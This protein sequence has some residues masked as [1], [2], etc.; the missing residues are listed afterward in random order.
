MQGH[1]GKYSVYVH[2]SEKASLG[3]IW[4]SKVFK[5]REIRSE[6]V[7]MQGFF[8]FSLLNFPLVFRMPPRQVEV[9]SNCALTTKPN[10]NVNFVSSPAPA[11][12]HIKSLFLRF[13][14]RLN[15]FYLSLSLSLSLSFI[16]LSCRHGVQQWHFPTK[17]LKGLGLQWL[18]RN[19]DS[20]NL[21]RIERTYLQVCVVLFRFLDTVS[22]CI[23]ECPD[24]EG[25]SPRPR[26]EN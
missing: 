15:S 26:A 9:T 22:M 20:T 24:G 12:M 25:S 10:Q 18:R 14:G 21:I 1:E 16:A 3:S 2:A 23:E 4:K 11:A 13:W 8:F 6:K 17:H 5:G 19:F 7:C